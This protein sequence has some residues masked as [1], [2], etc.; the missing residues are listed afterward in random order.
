L[1]KLFCFAGCAVLV[2]LLL[3]ACGGIAYFASKGFIPGVSEL[4]GATKPK[5]LGVTYTELDFESY[6]AKTGSTVEIIDS[7]ASP[8]ESIAFSVPRDYQQVAFTQ[9]EITARVNHIQWSYTPIRDVQVRFDSDGAIEMSGVLVMDNIISFLN[10]SGYEVSQE[11]INKAIRR[12]DI[13]PVDP[14]IYLKMVPVVVNNTA[15]ITIEAFELGRFSVNVDQYNGSTVLGE[16]VTQIFSQVDGFYAQS[17]TVGD[18][19]MTFDG[20][21]PTVVEVYT[22]ATE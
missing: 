16:L 10:A 13:I 17:V 4:L 5:D 15:T 8:Q 2:V 3:L 14:A 19:T 21:A 9:A 6:M 18:G 7:A 1:K 12:I 20:T 22:G 11:D